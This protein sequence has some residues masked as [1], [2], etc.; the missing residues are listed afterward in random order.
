M[1]VRT[2]E[3]LFS[4]TVKA[5]AKLFKLLLIDYQHVASSTLILNTKL[6]EMQQM[7]DI[8]KRRVREVNSR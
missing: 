2:W 8:E 3:R 4:L 5:S 6:Q 7:F 1:R